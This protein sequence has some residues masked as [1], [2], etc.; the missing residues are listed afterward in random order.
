MC[1]WLWGVPNIG[2]L[3]VKPG[4][5]WSTLSAWPLT[6]QACDIIRHIN[7]RLGS[8]FIKTFFQRVPILPSFLCL[9]HCNLTQVGLETCWF[10]SA[11]RDLP[12]HPTFN[13]VMSWP[14]V[15]SLVSRFWRLPWT[16]GPNTQLKRKLRYNPIQY[17]YLEPLATHS[18]HWRNRIGLEIG[19]EHRAV[20]VCIDFSAYGLMFGKIFC[21]C[22]LDL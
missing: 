5:K 10:W 20:G 8:V 6:S 19:N 17:A 9:L 11:K 18:A 12:R 15:S 2:T 22:K 13:E 3:S 14:K 1:Q 7:G 4:R 21:R 16:N